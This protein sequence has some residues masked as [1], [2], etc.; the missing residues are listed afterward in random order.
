[1]CSEDANKRLF[2]EAWKVEEVQMRERAI[3]ARFTE[4]LLVVSMMLDQ[5]SAKIAYRVISSSGMVSGLSL[6]YTV[7]TPSC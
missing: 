1:L 3:V 5:S 2:L 6:L 7:P 4:K